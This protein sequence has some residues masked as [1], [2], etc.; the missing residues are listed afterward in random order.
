MTADLWGHVGYAL[1]FGGQWLIA[2][3]DR[4]GWL[5]R[6]AGELTWCAVG[7]SL[8]LSSAVLWGLVFGWLELR[9]FRAWR[10]EASLAAKAR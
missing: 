3:R 10:A 8:G 2:K 1:L 6:L 4:R 7:L 5:L 9:G